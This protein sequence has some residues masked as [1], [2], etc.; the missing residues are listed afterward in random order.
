MLQKEF[1]FQSLRFNPCVNEKM[2]PNFSTIEK[3]PEALVAKFGLKKPQA[4][5]T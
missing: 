2:K 3:N 4:F 1:L 5:K